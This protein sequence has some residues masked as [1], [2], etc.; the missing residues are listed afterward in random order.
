MTAVVAVPQQEYLILRTP[1]EPSTD[2]KGS[3]DGVQNSHGSLDC[4]EIARC[5]V[6]RLS[7]V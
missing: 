3:E 2:H 5:L 7:P 6:Q 4:F 1:A